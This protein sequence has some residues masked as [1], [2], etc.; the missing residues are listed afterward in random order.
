MCAAFATINSK[1]PSLRM[2]QTGFQNTPV[3][4]IATWVQP[5]SVSQASRPC[6]PVVEVSNVRH[7]RGLAA[8]HGTNTGDDRR[9]VH[10][11]TGATRIQHVHGFSSMSVPPAWGASTKVNSDKRAPG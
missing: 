6:R 1:A 5:C 4:S 9:L 8:D 3:A 2:F 7:S 10:V 11:E